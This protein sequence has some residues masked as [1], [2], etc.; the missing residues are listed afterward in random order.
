[1]RYTSSTQQWLDNGKWSDPVDGE[2]IEPQWDVARLK[3]KGNWRTPNYD[4]LMEL[5]KICVNSFSEVECIYIN[6]FSVI[7]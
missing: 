1:M 2:D 3:W 5:I 6:S 7:E 4:E